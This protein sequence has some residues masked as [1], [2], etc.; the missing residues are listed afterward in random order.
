MLL[1]SMFNGSADTQ[2]KLLI[3]SL[4][5]KRFAISREFLT[6]AQVKGLRLE[7]NARF[8]SGLFRPARIGQSRIANARGVANANV[9]N[10]LICWLDP[11]DLR[12]AEENL[13]ANL[14]TLRELLN[15]ELYL[16]LKDF[17][18]HYARYDV[19]HRYHR[20]IDRFQ[21]DDARVI[22]V[23]LYLNE[24]WQEADGGQLCLYPPNLTPVTVTPNE[25]TFVCFTSDEI[26]HEVFASNTRERLSIAAWFR[27]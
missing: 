15:R 9:R 17:E 1:N 10:D 13:F 21:T 8:E 26:E 11:A 2:Q 19:G 22:S 3:D 16:G 27:R 12:P 5:V 18:A 4:A 20:H 6:K 14:E 24:N 7:S 23:V 25:Q